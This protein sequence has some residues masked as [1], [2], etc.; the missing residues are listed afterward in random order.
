MSRVEFMNE[1]VYLL[2]DI[3]DSDREEALQY[4]EDYFDDAGEENEDAIIRELGS[5]E[6]VAAIIKSG[7]L[8]NDED[9]GEFTEHGY[10]D[11]R[12]KQDYQVPERAYEQE[13]KQRNRT[14]SYG[15]PY[16]TEVDPKPRR[17]G[18]NGLGKVLLIIAICLVAIPIIFPVAGGIFGV[19]FGILG[20]IFGIAVGMIGATFGGVLGGMATFVG[21][22]IRIF[23]A[24]ARGFFLCASGLLM[25]AFGFLAIAFAVFLITKVAPRFIH[26]VIGWFRRIFQRKGNRR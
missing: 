3:A 8:G 20:G 24:P 11:W 9:A 10:E 15:N 4:Y 14:Y 23:T 2:Q 25:M 6:R 17:S 1:L 21:G 19:I 12:F 7:L 13:K 26:W 5:P 22:I 16:S 18:N